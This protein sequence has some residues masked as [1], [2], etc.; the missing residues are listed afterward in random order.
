MVFEALII[1][2]GVIAGIAFLWIMGLWCV[3]RRYHA[4]YSV[5]PE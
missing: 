2:T 3:L 4:Q 5:V 1:G